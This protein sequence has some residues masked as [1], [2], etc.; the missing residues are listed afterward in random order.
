M[1]NYREVARPTLLRQRRPLS[2]GDMVAGGR[3]WIDAVSGRVLKTALSVLG[4]DEITTLFRFD[5]R[6]QVAVPIIRDPGSSRS[7]LFDN[8]NPPGFSIAST[9]ANANA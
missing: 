8:R 1:V 2:D 5:D 7:A 6:F 4:S 3:L 9:F